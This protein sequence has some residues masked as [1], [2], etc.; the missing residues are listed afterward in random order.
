[1]VRLSGAVEIGEE[2]NERVPI[3]PNL[4]LR[5]LA[6]FVINVYQLMSQFPPRTIDPR[7]DEARPL[8]HTFPGSQ[9]MQHTIGLAL[10]R[11]LGIS[12]RW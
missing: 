8:T 2:R 6:L 3:T 4:P 12:M 11:L 5:F 9:F 10:C 7:M 1:M